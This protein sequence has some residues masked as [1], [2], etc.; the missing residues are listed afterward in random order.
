MYTS[1]RVYMMAEWKSIEF[2]S[3]ARSLFFGD[4]LYIYYIL[5]SMVCTNK[6]RM[7]VY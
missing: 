2:L 4:A 7:K 6:W 1:V 3:I 5:Y